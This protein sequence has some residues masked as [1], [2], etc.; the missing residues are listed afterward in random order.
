MLPAPDNSLLLYSRSE[1]LEDINKYNSFSYHFSESNSSIV[2]FESN[3]T[4]SDLTALK[5]TLSPS[6]NGSEKTSAS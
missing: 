3:P 5:D 4:E 1:E 2:V 6:R